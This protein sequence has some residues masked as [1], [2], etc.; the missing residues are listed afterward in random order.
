MKLVG[1][2]ETPQF[3]APGSAHA[4]TGPRGSFV[5]LIVADRPIAG[6]SW[7]D[8]GTAIEALTGG[9]ELTRDEP[10]T[11]R[12][13]TTAN[14][15]AGLREYVAPQDG[16]GW[17]DFFR[18]SDHLSLSITEAAYRRD[19]WISVEGGSFFKIRVLLAGRLLNRDGTI[20]LESPQA[21]L[22]V[23]AGARGGGYKIAGQVPTTLVVLHCGPELLSERVGLPLGEAP[24]PLRALAGPGP[25]A[26][27]SNRVSLTPEL[28]RAAQWIHASRYSVLST[29]RAAYLEALAMEMVCQIVTDLSAGGS[30]QSCG[31]S[32]L[33][34]DRRL[35]HEARD[36]LSQHYAS[37][38]T[39]PQL[40][41]MV[42][43][44]QTKLKAAFKQLL[45]VTI[46]EYV[47]QRRM[48]VAVQMLVE[49]ELSVAEIAYRVGYDYPANFSCAFKRYYGRLPRDWKHE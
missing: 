26:G 24:D 7:P 16:D 39:I 19:R 28:F 46:Y 41:R 20:L 47:L 45:N 31:R 44:N 49:A 17:W 12:S 25:A 36:Y 15:R 29:V 9:A 32:L 13:R 22:H 6:L 1:C 14:R 38:P 3:L 21:H 34:R 23:C 18:L 35:V 4:R 2:R 37:P 30:A 11:A 5:D 48:E 43:M 42:G 40:A 10:Q 8:Y 33:S 27:V